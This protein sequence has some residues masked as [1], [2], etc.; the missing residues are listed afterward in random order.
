MTQRGNKKASNFQI[1][2]LYKN[3]KNVWKVAKILGMCGQSVHERLVKLKKN[4]PTKKY[5]P[6]E[7]EEIKNLY[8]NGFC[9]GDGK[10]DK[11]CENLRRPKTNICRFARQLGLSNK[12]RKVDLSYSAANGKKVSAHL[13]I[14]GHP[15]GMLGKTHSQEY[16]EICKNRQI[17]WFK[18]ASGKQKMVRIRKALQTRIKKYGT[19]A[20]THENIAVTWKQ[21]WREIGGSRIYFRSRWEANYGRYL[22]WKK[23]RG[24]IKSWEHEP[25][26]FWFHKIKRGSVTYLPD[27]KITNIDESHYW[28][29]VKGWY[30]QRSKT[31][32]KRFKKY[33]PEEKLIL[34]DA[35]W[36][37]ENSKNMP[38]VIPDWENMGPT[39]TIPKK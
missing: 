2:K 9:R 21:G 39:K 34:V 1:L 25:Q 22:Q 16:K 33:Y 8:K 5:L 17:E 18:N 23:E 30:D 20:T 32:I 26:T 36:F 10:F 24:E 15:K 12:K 4:N 11:L 37:K 19:L 29:E 28:V 3:H 27:F 38:F 35:K 31:K 13:K 7:V 6:N 14:H